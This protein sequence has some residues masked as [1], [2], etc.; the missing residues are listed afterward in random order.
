MWKCLETWKLFWP[1]PTLSNLHKTAVAR[2]FLSNKRYRWRNE[3]GNLYSVKET[4]SSKDN[5][6]VRIFLLS[7][8]ILNLPLKFDSKL[9]RKIRKYKKYVEAFEVV[10]TKQRYSLSEI[11]AS[12]LKRFLTNSDEKSL[13]IMT[14][15]PSNSIWRRI[16]AKSLE[17]HW[18]SIIFLYF[19]KHT[20]WWAD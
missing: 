10:Y 6:K 20:A 16:A 2:M 12:L 17:H 15:Q 8:N 1:L 19:L 7:R 4:T 9:T 11:Q 5:K 3:C 18:I 13:F 14:T